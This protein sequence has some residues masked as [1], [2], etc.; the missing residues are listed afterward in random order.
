MVVCPQCQTENR[1]DRR[2]CKAC[3]S[4]L[5]RSCEACG[6]ANEPDDAFCGE[7]GARL[8]MTPTV[9]TASLQAGFGEHRGAD[10]AQM[11]DPDISTWP[12]RSSPGMAA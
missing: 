10:V 7:C 3:G 2:F 9:V 11:P 6:F 12:G 5:A 1:S 8:G 4:A